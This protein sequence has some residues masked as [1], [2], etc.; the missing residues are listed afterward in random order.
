MGSC[1]EQDLHSPAWRT[2]VLLCR[3]A[4]RGERSRSHGAGHIPAITPVASEMH[5]RPAGHPQLQRLAHLPFAV[6]DEPCLGFETPRC[7]PRTR[8]RAV[9]GASQCPGPAFDLPM[10][11]GPSVYSSEQDPGPLAVKPW[12]T[13]QVPELHFLTR[14]TNFLG[15]RS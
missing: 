11:K 6:H 13:R 4:G 9:M 15:L 2:L 14:K 12:T 1:W 5:P 8:R 10:C 3:S 7:C